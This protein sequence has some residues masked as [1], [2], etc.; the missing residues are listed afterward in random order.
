MVLVFWNICYLVVFNFELFFSISVV[1]VVLCF[2]VL[3]VSRCWCQVLC[4][5]FRLLVGCRCWFVFIVFIVLIC[6]VNNQVLQLKFVVFI[7]LWGCFRVIVR[8][9]CLLFISGGVL[10]QFRCRCLGRSMF[11]VVWIFFSWKCVMFL[12][13]VGRLI[14]CFFS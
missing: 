1:R 3:I 7:R 10:C 13:F 8:C 9:Q 11:C 5:V 12:L 6:C 4:Q 2:C 14:I